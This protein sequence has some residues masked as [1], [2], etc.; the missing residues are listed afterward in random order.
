MIT[1][2]FHFKILEDFVEV[3][4]TNADIMITKLKQQVGNDSFDIS[5]YYSLC[6]LDAICGKD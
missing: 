4:S 6:A 5:P 2:T 1:P 3:F